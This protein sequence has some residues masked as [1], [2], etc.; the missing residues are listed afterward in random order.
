[1]ISILRQSAFERRN[2]PV[3]IVLAA[4]LNFRAKLLFESG[5]SGFGP[6][7]LG[8]PSQFSGKR[9]VSELKSG[10]GTD[11]AKPNRI[12]VR[13]SNL[14]RSPTL[15]IFVVKKRRLIVSP[16]RTTK[17]VS[18]AKES[19]STMCC[20]IAPRRSEAK[21]DACVQGAR[22]VE[23]QNS[24]GRIEKPKCADASRTPCEAPRTHRPRTRFRRRSRDRSVRWSLEGRRSD[25]C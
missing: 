14:Q 24:G 1:M 25:A 11:E 15:P 23:S 9:F 10:D 13:P 4:R 3:Q 16:Y 21:R 20:G 17:R 2:L 6:F 12:E 8:T 22:H 18:P 19:A 7:V 5:D